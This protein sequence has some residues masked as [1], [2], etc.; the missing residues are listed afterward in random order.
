MR[1]TV[2]AVVRLDRSPNWDRLRSRIDGL[3]RLAPQFANACGPRRHVSSP[4]G[5][6][7]TPRRPRFPPAP[8]A[9]QRAGQL[10]PGARIHP[11]RGHEGLR[12][13]PAALGNSRSSK[14]LADGS[15]ALVTKVHHSTHRRIGGAQLAG[16]VLDTGPDGKDLGPLPALPVCPDGR[17]CRGWRAP[18]C[19]TPRLSQRQAERR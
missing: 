13:Q 4:R 11:G 9:R 3:T 14:G 5:G 6:R 18:R 16:L 8:V 12:S 17:R 19:P 7:P 1:S 10:G 2:V 15:A